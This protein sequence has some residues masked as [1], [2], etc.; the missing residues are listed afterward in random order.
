VRK[1]GI[2]LIS[3]LGLFAPV[4]S[5]MANIDAGDVKN[6]YVGITDVPLNFPGAGPSTT[7]G[8]YTTC[9]PGTRTL[10]GGAYL[11]P[12][13]T[14]ETPN[15]IIFTQVVSSSATGDGLGWYADGEN[16]SYTPNMTMRIIY[17]CLPT[18][19]LTDATVVADT[20]ALGSGEA[21]SV[22]AKCPSG[23]RVFTGGSFWHATG[24]GPDPANAND[25]WTSSSAPT[26]K[27]RG[28]YADGYAFT[29][30]E[31]T[32]YAWCLPTKQLVGYKAV[33][34]SRPMATN[35]DKVK[36]GSCP[37]SH[38]GAIA[39]GVFFH[40]PGKGPTSANAD[41]T[42]LSGVGALEAPRTF[43][44]GGRNIDMKDAQMTARAFCLAK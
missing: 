33:T 22:N 5:A 32:A 25:V 21:D 43:A 11:Y 10:T 37:K 38:P 28:W 20:A 31:L 39:A 24:V 27:G 2:L 41:D 34:S 3:V 13:G 1:R 6:A 44:G 30:I 29:S 17:K 35:S 40:K 18:A 12:T 9:P 19:K 15:A 8:A 7:E 26:G 4:S 36:R 42:H 14:A 16:G 23:S